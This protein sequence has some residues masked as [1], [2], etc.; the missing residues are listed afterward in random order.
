[1]ASAVLRDAAPI[2]SLQWTAGGEGN[3]RGVGEH[4]PS[5]AAVSPVLTV[6]Q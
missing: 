1:M 5:K 4:H 2:R 3:E 6:K